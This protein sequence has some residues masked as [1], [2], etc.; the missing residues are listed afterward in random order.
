M[1]L[2]CVAMAERANPNGLWMP[3]TRRE[4]ILQKHCEVEFAVESLKQ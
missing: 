4:F 1:V 3:V 2:Y